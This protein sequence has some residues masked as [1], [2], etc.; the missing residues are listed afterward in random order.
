MDK[1]IFKVSG[2]NMLGQI[3]SCMDNIYVDGESLRE[4]I[5]KTINNTKRKIYN[6]FE[7]EN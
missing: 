4:Y 1:L 2:I 3:M 5:Y 6:N 7:I